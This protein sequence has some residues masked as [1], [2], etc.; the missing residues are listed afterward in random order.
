MQ[1][2]IKTSFISSLQACSLNTAIITTTLDPTTVN[3]VAVVTVGTD[4]VV[5]SPV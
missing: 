4:I 1:Q 5:E 2:V 3:M